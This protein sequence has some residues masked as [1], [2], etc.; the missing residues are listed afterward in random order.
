MKPHSR[1]ALLVVGVVLLAGAGA[2][3][4]RFAEPLTATFTPG[5]TLRVAGPSIPATESMIV[6]VGDDGYPI[7]EQNADEARP[8]GSVTKMITALVVLERLPLLLGEQGPVHVPDDVDL[9]TYRNLGLDG[10]V[11]MPVSATVPLSERELLEAMLVSSSANHAVMLSRLATGSPEEYRQ[12]ANDWLARHGFLST[13]VVDAAGL[14]EL[15]RS[16]PRELTSIAR[17]ALAE[18][19]IAEIVRLAQV[20]IPGVGLR[21]ATN[22][23]LGQPGV[24]GMKTGTTE[25]A[26]HCLVYTAI[27]PDAEGNPVR[28]IG[29]LLGAATAESRRDHALAGLALARAVLSRE[30]P[31]AA[32]PVGE[33][34]S[35]WGG[36]VP[37]AV[38][39]LPPGAWLLSTAEVTVRPGGVGEVVGSIVVWSAVG[40]L[41]VDLVA[42]EPLPEPDPW[43]RLT[44]PGMN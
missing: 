26:G 27:V 15:N 7:F 25:T 29:V 9:A 35:M 40:P 24:D 8:L 22:P 42:L 33:L 23:V 18:P 16:T 12:A 39:G 44:R 38:V 2:S 13:T 37:V 32:T 4:A 17:L 34:S 3:A 11:V 10:A 41:D 5:D 30:P 43:W 28:V 20:D 14:S 36:G 19:V 31:S 6:A 21:Q 1:V